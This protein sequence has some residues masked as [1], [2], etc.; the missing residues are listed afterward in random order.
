MMFMRISIRQYNQGE[1]MSLKSA[2][3]QDGLDHKLLS[4][5]RRQST[6]KQLKRLVD[7]MKNIDEEGE[8]VDFD[9]QV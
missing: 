5:E 8:F 6:K 1:R 9:P 7:D 3:G 4:R 2:D